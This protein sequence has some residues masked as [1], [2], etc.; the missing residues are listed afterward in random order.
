M[1]LTALLCD[2]FGMR[3]DAW[4]LRKDSN[5]EKQS[6]SLLCY[7]LHHGEMRVKSQSEHACENEKRDI[8]VVS[9]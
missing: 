2:V 9:H 7:R 3:W 1:I 5:L 4:L 6:Q 8:A